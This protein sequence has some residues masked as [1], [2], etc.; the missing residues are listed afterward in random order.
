MAFKI[1]DRVR[2]AAIT[3][4]TPIMRTG[5]I[6][7]YITC[8]F[9]TSSGG[10]TCDKK[11]CSHPVREYIWVVWPVSSTSFSYYHMELV[12]ET[13]TSSP[14]ATSIPVISPLESAQTRFFKG[15]IDPFVLS[16]RV[17]TAPIAE[18]TGMHC[19]GKYC[20]QF[21]PLAE[22]NMADGKSFKCHSC[23]NSGR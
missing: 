12:H 2:I 22:P 15:T 11:T 18:K 6:V 20:N 1:G 8:K 7:K 10:K 21:V 3:P 5:G 16:T 13:N 14:I 17:G 23:R 19:V 4:N 9:A